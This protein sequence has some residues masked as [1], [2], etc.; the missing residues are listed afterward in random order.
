MGYVSCT[1]NNPS[2][3]IS[4]RTNGYVDGGRLMKECYVPNEKIESGGGI[5]SAAAT[6]QDTELL[7]EEQNLITFLDNVKTDDFKVKKKVKKLA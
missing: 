5:Y 3:K 7:Q 2:V 6:I 1:N 4:V